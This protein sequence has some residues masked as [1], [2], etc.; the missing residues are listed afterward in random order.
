MYMRIQFTNI[1]YHYSC[2]T[3]LFLQYISLTVFLNTCSKPNQTVS[4][5]QISHNI[6]ACLCMLFIHLNWERTEPS[7]RN[8]SSCSGS[9]FFPAIASI[10]CYISR[11]SRCISVLWCISLS[12]LRACIRLYVRLVISVW[13]MTA[14]VQSLRKHCS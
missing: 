12:T 7:A 13:S 5:Y 2:Y 6:F 10:P 4:C 9:V 11:A 14:S 3:L 8:L 1:S